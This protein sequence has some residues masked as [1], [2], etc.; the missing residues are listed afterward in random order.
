MG[1]PKRATEVSTPPLETVSS[2]M[3]QG[4][5]HETHDSP[6]MAELFSSLVPGQPLGILDLGPS[7]SLNFEFYSKVASRVRFAGLFHRSGRE[8]PLSPPKTGL[9]GWWSKEL[10]IDD[11]SFDLIFAWDVFNYLDAETAPFLARHLAALSEPG[12]RLHIMINANETI[13]ARP[14]RY[15]IAEPGRL[16]YRPT[17]SRVTTAPDPPPAQVESWLDPFRVT[18]SVILRHGVREFIAVYGRDSMYTAS[19]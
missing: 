5:A 17:T 13:P 7:I 4:S 14:C 15:E 1:G 12:A 8:E 6:A 2:P 18:R 19:G 3:L 10:P 9:T 16:V 11:H